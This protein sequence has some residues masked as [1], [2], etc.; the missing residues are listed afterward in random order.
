LREHYKTYFW[1][2]NA[3]AILVGDFHVEQALGMFD[4]EFGA[5]APSTKPIP[6]V[7]TVEPPQEGERRVVIKRP[8]GAG[9]V[10]AAY[11][12]PGAQDP[13]FMPLGV[14]STIL[15][16]SLNSRLY[17]ALVETQISSSVGS[18]NH[19]LRDP[20]VLLVQTTVARGST[21]Q[22]AEEALK[23]AL[24]EFASN[25]VTEEEVNPSQNQINTTP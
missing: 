22:R 18:T 1:P 23:A 6:R 11:I 8:G 14:L 4:R 19:A 25:A 21:H 9:M 2:N 5:F 3:E 17:Q 16:Q 7:V 24:H 12:R 15:T 20:F 13:D 10:Q